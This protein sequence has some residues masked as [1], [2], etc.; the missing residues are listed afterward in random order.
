MV[1]S[2]VGALRGSSA[3]MRHSIAWHATDPDV[4]KHRGLTFFI[5][6][7]E[8]EGVEVRPLRQITGEAEF[9]EV[10]FTDAPVPKENLI[11]DVGDGWR[12]QLKI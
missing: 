4:P 10:Y 2:E 11:G 7:M 1:P 6:D 3:L 12:V 9:N 5:V 8:G